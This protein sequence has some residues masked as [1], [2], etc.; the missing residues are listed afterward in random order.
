[1][2]LQRNLDHCATVVNAQIQEWN[3]TRSKRA[4]GQIDRAL[5]DRES[6]LVGGSHA[7]SSAGSSARHADKS[8]E[9]KENMDAQSTSASPRKSVQGGLG[10]GTSVPMPLS[11]MGKEMANLMYLN[12]SEKKDRKHSYYRRKRF[13]VSTRF[14]YS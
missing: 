2:E 5:A 3:A 4:S 13:A 1:M 11:P 8:K 10:F 14:I 6:D 12:G 7:G 9:D